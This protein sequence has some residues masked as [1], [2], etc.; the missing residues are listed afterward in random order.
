MKFT[1]NLKPYESEAYFTVREHLTAYLEENCP[2]P[3]ECSKNA[4]EKLRVLF[5]IPHHFTLTFCQKSIKQ[6]AV[7]L[8]GNHDKLD[9]PHTGRRLKTSE[10]DTS[11]GLLDLSCSFPYVLNDYKGSG[12]L[13]IDPNASLGVPAPFV[14]IF[15]V[16]ELDLRRYAWKKNDYE[17]R[18]YIWLLNKVLGDVFKK[19]V[20]DIKRENDYKAVLLWQTVENSPY[21]TPL[22]EKPERSKT[23]IVAECDEWVHEKILKMGYQVE[24]FSVSRSNRIAIANYPVHSKELIELFSDRISGI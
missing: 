9:D 22:A 19:G 1:I 24:S 17:G 8:F 7:H 15:H 23:V 2:D 21:L 20:D 11:G 14:M 12:G 5:N 16:P 3:M 4:E 13:L 18:K 10:V 6:P